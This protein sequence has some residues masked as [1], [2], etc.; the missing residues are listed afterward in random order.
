[1]YHFHKNIFV[2]LSRVEQLV[3]EKSFLSIIGTGEFGN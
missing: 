3:N 2:I 1:M